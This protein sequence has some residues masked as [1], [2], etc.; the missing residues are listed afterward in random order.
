LAG[1]RYTHRRD[2]LIAQNIS[3]TSPVILMVELK[4]KAEKASR[5]EVRFIRW[6][7]GEDPEFIDDLRLAKSY[8]S[9]D[10]IW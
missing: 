1:F 6:H 2:L 8:S 4:I 10:I 3:F 5:N 9:G 7:P